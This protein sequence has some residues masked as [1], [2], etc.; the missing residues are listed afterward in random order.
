M[1]FKPDNNKEFMNHL[2]EL[3]RYIEKRNIFIQHNV[4]SFKNRLSGSI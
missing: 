1:I 3:T 4:N 2:N